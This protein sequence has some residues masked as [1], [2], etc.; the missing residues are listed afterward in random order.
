[1]GEK[2]RGLNSQSNKLCDLDVCRSIPGKITRSLLCLLD[3]YIKAVIFA[4]FLSLMELSKNV[5][6]YDL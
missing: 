1:M 3:W 6:Q 4:S 5:I 2:G